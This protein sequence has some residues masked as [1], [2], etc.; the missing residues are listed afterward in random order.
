MKRGQ[1]TLFVILGL[2]ILLLVALGAYFVYQS[3]VQTVPNLVEQENLGVIQTDIEFCLRELSKEKLIQISLTG[4]LTEEPLTDLP[5]AYLNTGVRLLNYDIPYW[6]RLDS[7]PDCETCNFR[8]NVPS[9]EGPNSIAQK[10]SLYVEENLIDCL[11]NF[12]AF[13][14]FNVEYEDFRVTTLFNQANTQVELDMPIVVESFDTGETLRANRFRITHDLE[15]RNLYEVATDILFS[16]IA[17]NN[18]LENYIITVK[19]LRSLGDWEIPPRSGGVEYGFS[20]PRMWRTSEVQSILREEF[21]ENINYLQIEGS[22]NYFL[23]F[24]EDIYA[25]NIYDSFLYNIPDNP[26]LQDVK[27]RFHYFENMPLYVN[28]NP[29][30]GELIMPRQNSHSIARFFQFVTTEYNFVYDITLPVVI[31]LEDDTAFGGEGLLFQFAVEANVRN[32]DTYD[33]PPFEAQSELGFSDLGQRSVPIT[34]RTYDGYT[35]QPL[36]GVSL[37]VECLDSTLSLGE[38][39][40]RSSL[41]IV[42]SMM[43]PCLDARIVSFDS[44]Y[45]AEEKI[46]S[47]SAGDELELEMRFYEERELDII[48]EKRMLS[49]AELDPVEGMPRHEWV[50]TNNL[51]VPEVDESISIIFTRIGDVPFVRAIEYEEGTSIGLVPGQYEVLVAS[52][53]NL[54]SPFET[55]KEVIVIQQGTDFEVIEINET[56]FNDSILF[57]FNQI[58]SDEPYFIT[59]ENLDRNNVIITYAGYDLAELVYTRHL[60][61]FAD[62]FS[63]GEQRRSIFVPRFS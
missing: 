16:T 54:D 8:Y 5:F 31:S 17:S 37:S 44:D 62:M 7:P 30:F 19:D 18:A 23:N 47:A 13:P 33:V 26:K 21:A 10:V 27:V 48:L 6:L 14:Q 58:G 52:T 34:I 36:E 43:P 29:S 9:L 53:L 49:R 3:D 32:S 25:R 57:G 38:S 1:V 22:R 56:V 40:M 51:M 12:N 28:V 46:V 50:Y 55:E 24:D 63:V 61:V 2:I 60:D 41:A 42:E 15:Y 11:N 35:N 39:E 45:F 4:G 20:A 59:P